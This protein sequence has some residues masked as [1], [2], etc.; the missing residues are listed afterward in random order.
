MNT[1]LAKYPLACCLVAVCLPS[2]TVAQVVSPHGPC[3]THIELVDIDELDDGTTSTGADR[4]GA[5]GVDHA[6]DAASGMALIAHTDVS[7]GRCLIDLVLV[8]SNGD[9]RPPGPGGYEFFG[10]W[11]VDSWGAVGT[12]KGDP[13][14][15]AGM[16]ALYGKRLAGSHVGA[17]ITGLT[18]N[19]TND[20]SPSTPEGY[21][22]V[23]MWDVTNKIGSI[24]SDGSKGTW[25][26][27]LGVKYGCQFELQSG[28]IDCGVDETRGLAVVGSSK[29]TPEG[30]YGIRRAI[31]SVL[32][33][34]GDTYPPELMRGYTLYVTNGETSD[35][36]DKLWVINNMHV[37]VLK[38][39]PTELESLER[40]KLRG[41]ARRDLAWASQGMTCQTGN[42]GYNLTA[43]KRNTTLLAANKAKIAGLGGDTETTLT[44]LQTALEAD[45][46]DA[47]KIKQY[48][49]LVATSNA[50]RGDG[51]AMEALLPID[52][53]YRGCDHAVHESAHGI[54][55]RAGNSPDHDSRYQGAVEPFAG[56]VQKYFGAA[57]G[58]PA[59]LPP[60]GPRRETMAA[61]F[62]KQI[63]LPCGDLEKA[64]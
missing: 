9:T 4:V 62:T 15:N 55:L 16:A 14:D 25:M 61:L 33:V 60:A 23:G 42:I 8:P 29:T 58:A 34:M 38:V 52:T 6:D 28:W 31:T 3:I 17:V 47:D 43:K 57:H 7:K 49:D 24:G 30:T 63:T 2:Q 39:D 40:D 32:E 36:L 22:Y 19:A 27:T 21:G 59:A 50:A 5:W 48:N 53:R 51:K 35:E 56:D 64:D 37:D 10:A 26:M 20:R 13:N 54:A 44:T 41:G 12:A 45:S 1:T 18:L 11:N 46:G